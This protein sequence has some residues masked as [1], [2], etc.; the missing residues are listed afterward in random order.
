VFFARGRISAKRD[1][2]PLSL[3]LIYCSA[4]SEAP[5]PPSP[6]GD[7]TGAA[8]ILLVDDSEDFREVTSAVLEKAGY[9]VL[10]AQSGSDAT[11]ILEQHAGAIQ[12]L[13]T[14][15]QMPGMTGPQLIERTALKYPLIRLLCMSGQPRDAELMASVPF[16]QKPFDRMTLLAIVQEILAAGGKRGGENASAAST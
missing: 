6:I 1:G 11:E 15:S 13:I 12:L 16:L 4:E 14:D 7:A 10:E 3:S 2:I 5:M 9:T 8:T